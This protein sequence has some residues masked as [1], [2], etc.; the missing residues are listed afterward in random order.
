MIARIRR[1]NTWINKRSRIV[2][3]TIKSTL[4]LIIGLIGGTV[5]YF[6]L[7]I[8]LGAIPRNSDLTPTEDG[9]E[10][11]VS[12]NG[13]H[14]DYIFPFKT[15]EFDWATL[16]PPEDFKGVPSHHKYSH[17]EIGWG[18]KDF[19]I[20]VPQWSD[21][22]LSMAFEALF[23]SSE[24]ALHVRYSWPPKLD[25]DCKRTVI[26]R[27]QYQRLIQHIKETV[28]TDE[29]GRVKLISVPGY[30]DYDRF[31]EAHGS[32][33]LI[34]NCN[35]WTGSGLRQAGIRT[36]VWT[37]LPSGILDHFD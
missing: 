27:D 31:Y 20:N 21:L 28:Q 17:I 22:T 29:Q 24:S 5:L 2:R 25:E 23:L 15:S 11:F 35:E 26:S 13:V 37:P 12:S 8:I 3:I 1:I 9:I 18:D 33:N 19:Y 36:G 34:G 4:S 10:I 14:V 32:Y 30:T 16:F 7:A 6:L